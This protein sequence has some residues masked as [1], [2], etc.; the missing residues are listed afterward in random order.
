MPSDTRKPA[1]GLLLQ[2]RDEFG[3]DLSASFMVGDKDLDV[4]CGKNAGTRTIWLAHD[5][6]YLPETPADFTT[7]C[8][9]EAADWILTQ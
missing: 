5:T 8:L 2:A 6:A 4:A 7:T 1:P 9:I 3:V